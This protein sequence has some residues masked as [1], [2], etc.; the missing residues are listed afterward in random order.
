M[1]KISFNKS[2]LEILSSMLQEEIAGATFNKH[3]LDLELRQ[4]KHHDM[5]DMAK[6]KA[7]EIEENEK[8]LKTLHLLKSKFD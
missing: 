8:R 3:F 2:E 6:N 5:D 1:K 4:S 7:K